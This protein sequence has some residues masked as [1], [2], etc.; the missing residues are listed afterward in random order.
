M[1]NSI[2]LM[3]LMVSVLS[4]GTPS[5][6]RVNQIHNE[7]IVAAK[8]QDWKALQRAL[9]T[10][11][12]EGAT[13]TVKMAR[14]AGYYRWIQ[15]QSNPTPASRTSQPVIITPSGKKYH[16]Q[17]CIHGRTGSPISLDA[18]LSRGYEACK[19]CGGQ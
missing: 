1:R 17:G 15:K 12:H 5:Q 13:T 10:A 4:Y 19:R 7:V 6:Q 8:A 3:W 9:R 18:A 16:N 11:E 14:E 2:I